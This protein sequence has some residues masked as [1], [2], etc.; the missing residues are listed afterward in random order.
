MILGKEVCEVCR[1][2]YNFFATGLT[3]AI[4]GSTDARFY[5]QDETKTTLNSH[6]NACKREEFAT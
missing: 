5:L 4:K 6:F 2:F 1:V 3:N